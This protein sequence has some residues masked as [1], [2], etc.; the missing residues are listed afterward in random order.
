MTDTATTL[1]RIENLEDDRA[2]RQSL[3]KR[4]TESEARLQDVFDKIECSDAVVGEVKDFLFAVVRNMGSLGSR[5]LIKND[6]TSATVEVS[7]S[8]LVG[9]TLAELDVS[10]KI[11]LLILDV[12]AGML[13]PET[14]ETMETIA[15]AAGMEGMRTVSPSTLERF[16]NEGLLTAFTAKIFLDSKSLAAEGDTEAAERYFVEASEMALKL[17]SHNYL[18]N[19]DLRLLAMCKKRYGGELEKL[20][21]AQKNIVS[22]GASP[23]EGHP[24][25]EKALRLLLRE[26]FGGS[27]VESMNKWWEEAKKEFTPLRFAFSQIDDLRRRVQKRMR[28]IEL[29]GPLKDPDLVFR[30]TQSRLYEMLE[31][32]QAD[33]HKTPARLSLPSSRSVHLLDVIR[34]NANVLSLPY[35]VDGFKKFMTREDLVDEYAQHNVAAFRKTIPD[36]REKLKS[37]LILC[38]ELY[39]CAPLDEEQKRELD[40]L[41]REIVD[42]VESRGLS[43]PEEIIRTR[44]NVPFAEEI[45]GLLSTREEFD[46]FDK[47][48]TRIRQVYDKTTDRSPEEPFETLES[49]NR[50]DETLPRGA[51]ASVLRKGTSTILGIPSPKLKECKS[52][53]HSPERDEPPS[54]TGGP[55]RTTESSRQTSLWKRLFR[56]WKWFK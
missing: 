32:L 30:R 51:A 18:D 7:W 33:L 34:R 43:V 20:V 27:R 8:Q 21:T 35:A 9:S 14:P 24:A 12:L 37:S 5:L 52:N 4:K 31:E 46:F 56:P 48:L 53:A 28:N 50:P 19:R 1:L 54:E 45:F 13:P 47:W 29:E 36:L 26:D 39:R 40:E 55:Q 49:I 38:D 25:L 16:R 41:R 22:A 42:Y 11:K 17:M 23:R 3:D 10:T 44:W 2:R 15:R 6:E